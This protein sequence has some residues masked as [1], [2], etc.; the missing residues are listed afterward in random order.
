MVEKFQI[1]FKTMAGWRD[2]GGTNLQGGKCYSVVQHFEWPQGP[3]RY[4]T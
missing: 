3:F 1:A 4:Q 2:V